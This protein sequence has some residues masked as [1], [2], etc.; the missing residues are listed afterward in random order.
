MNI[1]Q[2][3]S[4][5]SHCCW[6]KLYYKTE[7]NADFFHSKSVDKNY[8]QHIFNSIRRIV[9]SNVYFVVKSLINDLRSHS[10]CCCE[11]FKTFSL[12]QVYIR[13]LQHSLRKDLLCCLNLISY[14]FE[15]YIFIKLE[16]YITGQYVN[17]EKHIFKN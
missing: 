10:Q 8:K 11:L 12:Y 9:K 5:D 6:K 14:T 13:L 16:K 2:Q 17:L 7:S 4:K 3:K 1:I 15:L